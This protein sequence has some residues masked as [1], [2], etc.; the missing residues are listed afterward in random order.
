M[1]IRQNEKEAIFMGKRAIVLAGGGSRG[2]YQIGVWKALREL[3][4]DYQLVTGSSVGALNGALMV[5][6]DFDAAMELWENISTSDVMSDVLSEPLPNNSAATVWSAFIRDMLEQG[7]C[8]IAP[9][10]QTLRRLLDEERFRTSPIDFGLVTVEYP[11]MKPLELRKSQLPQGQV[12]DY[13]LASS[14]CFPAFKLKEIDGVKYMDGGYHDNMPMNLA[15]SM[16]ATELIAI[17][18]QSV[19]LVR[20][21]KTASGENRLVIHSHWNLGPFIYFDKSY[22]RRNI[23]LGYLDG[24]RAFGRCYGWKF[25][26]DP[27]DCQRQLRPL[28]RG[29]YNLLA[30]ARIK[31]L[32][33]VNSLESTL[34]RSLVRDLGNLDLETEQMTPGRLLLRMAEYGGEIFGL[35]PCQLQPL[36]SFHQQLLAGLHK[37]LREADLSLGGPGSITKVVEELKTHD[38]GYICAFLYQQLNLFLEPGPAPKNLLLFAPVFPEELMAALYLLLL[39]RRDLDSWEPKLF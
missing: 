37:V 15:L 30:Q 19:G 17:D 2:A 14:A 33:L 39:Q 10:E 8:D 3:G 7:G 21:P 16:G 35:D 31:Q 4:I 38:R 36:D 34:G 29:F 28:L 20:R 5:Q 9:L 12:C 22:A 32:G 25:A 23:A 13:L 26:F 27:Q 11:S 6:G 18:L 1:E 24:L